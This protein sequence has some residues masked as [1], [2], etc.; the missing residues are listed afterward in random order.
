MAI[1]KPH[2][3]HAA[4]CA[5]AKLWERKIQLEKEMREVNIQIIALDRLLKPLSEAK[6]RQLEEARKALK[7]LPDGSGNPES[8]SN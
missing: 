7:G 2:D 4:E 6:Q 8:D 3:R 1:L 5:K